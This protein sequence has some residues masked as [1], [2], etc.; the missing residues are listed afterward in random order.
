[1]FTIEGTAELD[2]VAKL[3]DITIPEDVEYDT[4]GGFLTGLLER[5]PNPDEQPEIEFDFVKF[6]VLSVEDRR[7]ASIYAEKLPRPVE[8]GEEEEE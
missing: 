8:E 3:L 4:I 5:I 7:I 1:M 2:E 6:K